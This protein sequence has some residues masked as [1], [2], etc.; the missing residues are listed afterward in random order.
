MSAAVMK[1]T[2]TLATTAGNWVERQNHRSAMYQDQERRN[3][4]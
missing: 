2:I 1:G 4:G 3:H